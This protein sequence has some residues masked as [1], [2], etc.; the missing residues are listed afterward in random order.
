MA[1]TLYIFAGSP[2]VRAVQITA[3]AIGLELNLKELDFT[4]G[5]HLQPEY[6][7]VVPI[8]QFEKKNQSRF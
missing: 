2:V 7:K 3:K 8:V 1:P 5:E 4:K 6:L